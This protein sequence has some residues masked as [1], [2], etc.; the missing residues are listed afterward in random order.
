MANGVALTPGGEIVI[1]GFTLG[2][3]INRDFLLTRYRADGGLDTAFGDHGTVE[4]DVSGGDDFAEN[5]AVDVERRIVLVGRATSPTIL[6]LALV[7]YHPDGTL[8]TGFDRDGILTADFHG[9]GE[10]GQDVTLDT[11]GRIVAAGYTANGSDT[12]FALVRANP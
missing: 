2:A 12:E 10:F 11:G 3:G 6:D 1:A 8:D 4:T 9:S 7:R 5:L